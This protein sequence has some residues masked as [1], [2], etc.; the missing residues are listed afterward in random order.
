M[1]DKLLSKQEK[2][3]K[4]TQNSTKFSK[5]CGFNLIS[6]FQQHHILTLVNNVNVIPFG[7]VG[8]TL[9]DPVVVR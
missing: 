9:W 5:L 7:C 2:W 6:N 3:S 1:H 4:R 8:S